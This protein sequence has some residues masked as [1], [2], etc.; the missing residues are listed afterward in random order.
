MKGVHAMRVNNTVIGQVKDGRIEEAVAAAMEAAKIVGRHGGEVRAFLSSA[1]G[2]QVNA[3][4][5]TMEYE[6][7]EELGRAMDAMATDTEL[8]AFTSRMYGPGSPT[9]ITSQS[10][11]MELPIREPKAGRGNVLEVHASKVHPGRLEEFLSDAVEVCEFVEANGAVNAR[12]IQLTYAGLASG[13]VAFCWELE[14]MS[15]QAK[16]SAGW[17]SDAGIAIQA[18]GTRADATSTMLSSALY[19]AIPL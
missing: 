2:E 6:S 17:F 10:L 1:A 16:T 13:M 14:S 12:V 8:Q 11:G 19:N 7:P 4:L 15:A 9:V 18:K 3:T 5:F